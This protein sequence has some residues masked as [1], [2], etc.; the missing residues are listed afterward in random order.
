MALRQHSRE[1]WDAVKT[2]YLTGNLKLRE[3]GEK[4]GV[5]H[6]AICR[7]AKKENWQELRTKL[8]READERIY[9]TLIDT[10]VS[11]NERAIAITD[12]LLAKIEQSSKTVSPDDRNAIKSLVV[13]LQGLREMEVFKVTNTESADIRVDMA[14]AE[15]YSD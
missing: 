8:Q 4:Y 15:E 11:N 2:E 3:I 6:T 5:D 7:R 1:T 10:K 14:S 9:N 12:T 13:S